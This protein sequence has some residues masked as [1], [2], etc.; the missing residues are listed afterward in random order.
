MARRMPFWKDGFHFFIFIFASEKK[1]NRHFFRPIF[2]MS[3]GMDRLDTLL[4]ARDLGEMFLT[5]VF[6]GGT[7]RR[8]FFSPNIFDWWSLG[9]ELF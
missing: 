6:I 8:D 2:L 3:R 1:K 9:G 4:A 7:A 5:N